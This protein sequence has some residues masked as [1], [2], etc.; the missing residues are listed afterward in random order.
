MASTQRIIS[1]ILKI[2]VGPNFRLHSPAF[3]SLREAVARRGVTEQYYG[4]S[5]ES[6]DLMWV[7]QWPKNMN[8]S[9]SEG[10]EGLPE[11]REAVKALDVNSKPASWYL[12][13]DDASLVRPALTAPLCQLCY[14][15]VNSTTLTETIAESLHKTFT[16]CYYAPGFTGGYWGTATNDD[17]MHYYYLGWET[18]ETELFDVEI[19]KL[20]PHMDS[21][22]TDYVKLTQQLGL[23]RNQPHLPSKLR[24]FK[25]QE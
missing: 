5:T 25:N 15:H 22:G 13:F 16:D 6:A 18:R 24:D 19:D 23:S 1:E 21:G 4:I 14:L 9:A 3:A 7:I 8:P 11:F 12:P 20:M 17:K 2:S 10:P